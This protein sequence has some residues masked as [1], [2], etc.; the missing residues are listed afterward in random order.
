VDTLKRSPSPATGWL[1]SDGRLAAARPRV[2]A[3]AARTAGLHAGSAAR[4]G[5]RG[6]TVA[7]AGDVGCWGGGRGSGR[8]EPRGSWRQ[9]S[10]P[11]LS[12]RGTGML[13]GFPT[14]VEGCV[15][16]GVRIALRTHISGLV[17]PD[18][19]AGSY[20]PARVDARRRPPMG[21]GSP[22]WPVRRAQL[23]CPTGSRARSR[24][25]LIPPTAWRGAAAACRPRVRP[26]GAAGTG[27]TRRLSTVMPA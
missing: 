7:R 15:R 2:A 19:L 13:A 4:A 21:A 22:A 14:R 3:W 27:D 25:Q 26:C 24:L 17:R 18:A 1:H 10:W 20:V 6:P 8:W 23:A 9:P 16:A 5:G 11:R 12:R